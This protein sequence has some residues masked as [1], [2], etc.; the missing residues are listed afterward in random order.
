MSSFVLER[1]SFVLESSSAL[2]K[3][4]C[5]QEVGHFFLL[6]QSIQCQGQSR[7]YLMVMSIL[8]WG[9][10]KNCLM[11]LSSLSVMDWV[12]HRMMELEWSREEELC[13]SWQMILI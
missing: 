9:Q 1:N 5:L 11:G 12:M 13:C 3:S 10:N 7:K 6:E 8:D 2:V 4:S